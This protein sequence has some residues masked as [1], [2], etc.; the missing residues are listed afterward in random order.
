MAKMYLKLRLYSL[1]VEHAREVLKKNYKQIHARLILT[2]AFIGQE[3]Y[4]QAVDEIESIRAEYPENLDML[5]LLATAYNR[6]GNRITAIELCTKAIDKYPNSILPMITI[7]DFYREYG[8]HNSAV[9]S[10]RTALDRFPENPIVANNLAML[11]LENENYLAEA[12]KLAISLLARFPDNPAIS[13]T[14]GWVYYHG[15]NYK[16]AKQLFARSLDLDSHNP[17]T[18]LHLAKTVI[19]LGEYTTEKKALA[20]AMILSKSRPFDG[21][22][23]IAPLLEKVQEKITVIPQAQE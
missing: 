10:Y 11:L 1:A 13:D 2:K 23:E 3:R 7:G 20:S 18:Y 21:Q 8:E 4:Q 15:G 6:L 5:M 16:Q 12:Y 22:N 17:L 19:K 9:A 14:I